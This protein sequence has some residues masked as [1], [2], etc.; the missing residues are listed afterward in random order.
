M[1]VDQGGAGL[2]GG[3]HV[4]HGWKL[5]EVEDDGGGDVLGL[6]SRRREADRQ[7]FTDLPDLVLGKDRLLGDLETGEPRNGPDRLHVREVGRREHVVAKRLRYVD[8]P[9]TGMR[10]GA[11]D[12]GD[13]LQAG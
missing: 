7:Q 10:Q 1:L 3:E 2:A 5:F 11:A 4:V 12:E 6:R 13:V 9:D 8:R